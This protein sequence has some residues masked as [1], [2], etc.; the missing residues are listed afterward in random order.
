MVGDGDGADE[1]EEVN[2]PLFY[3]GTRPHPENT[4]G[5]RGH[6]AGPAGIRFRI[7]CSGSFVVCRV[8]VRRLRAHG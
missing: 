6:F 1:A 7:G 2:F 4:S 3:T 8:P 5:S